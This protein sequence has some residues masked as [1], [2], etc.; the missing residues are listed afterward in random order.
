MKIVPAVRVANLKRESADPRV[1]SVQQHEL[2]ALV[3]ADVVVL[4]LV[5]I[6]RDR[7]K[8]LVYHATALDD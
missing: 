8:C 7:G 2:D 3:E 4:L 1:F 5:A 6:G